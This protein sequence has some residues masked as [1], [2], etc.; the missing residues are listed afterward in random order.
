[1]IE[2][3]VAVIAFTIGTVLGSFYTL[4]IY[5]IPLNQDITHERSYCPKCNHKLNFI[6]LI[7]ILSYV[8]LRGKCRYCGDKIRPRYLILEISSGILFMLYILSLRLDYFNLQTGDLVNILF[9]MIY[10][11]VLAITAGIDLENK[12]IIGNM[13]KF[14][15]I[16]SIIYMLYLYIL[17]ANM[18]RYIIYF[19]IIVCLL[20]I[21]KIKPNYTLDVVAYILLILLYVGTEASIVAIILTLITIALKNIFNIIRKKQKE[22]KFTIA[23]VFSIITIGIIIIQNYIMV[24]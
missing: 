9:G 5:R 21:G 7:P 12:K 22:E 10:L 8:F 20:I 17:G 24:R 4:A 14:T 19:I 13:M 18:Y 23:G 16:I 2:I 11:S 15:I 1:M 6:D 3:L